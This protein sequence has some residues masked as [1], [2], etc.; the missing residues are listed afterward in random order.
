MDKV[1][2]H[3]SSENFIAY[4]LRCSLMDILYEERNHEV[5]IENFIIV[6]VP[7]GSLCIRFIKLTHNV[8]VVSSCSL[9]S[10]PKLINGS[11][12]NLVMALS[13]NLICFISFTCHPCFIL[14]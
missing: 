13:W 3:L 14:R 5:G 6:R 10:P 2:V 8:E 7:W 12:L 1:I 11:L 9:V 4:F